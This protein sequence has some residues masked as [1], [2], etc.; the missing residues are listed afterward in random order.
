MS[1]YF[2]FVLKGDVHVTMLDGK[3]NRPTKTMEAGMIFGFR[4]HALS[5]DDFATSK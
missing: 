5:R 4:D 3:E 2:Y 1:D